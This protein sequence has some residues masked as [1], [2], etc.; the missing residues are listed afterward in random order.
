MKVLAL[1]LLFSTKLYA[2]PANPDW[3]AD[4]G[5]QKCVFDGN[6]KE[7]PVLM[8]ALSETD[9]VLFLPE[10]LAQ[11]VER[12]RKLK[13]EKHPMFEY[14]CRTIAP[15]STRKVAD[16]L[17][18]PKDRTGVAK[19]SSNGAR[20][21]VDCN[22]RHVQIRADL[23]FG[24]QLDAIRNMFSGLLLQAGSKAFELELGSV[25]GK[26][27]YQ[28]CELGKKPTKS[29]TVTWENSDKI[30]FVNWNKLDKIH[31]DYVPRGCIPDSLLTG[32]KSDV[33]KKDYLS[34]LLKYEANE[35]IYN[36]NSCD[37]IMY[38]Q[39][40]DDVSPSYRPQNAEC[41]KV[42]IPEICKTLRLKH[43][44]ENPQNFFTSQEIRD[45][46]IEQATTKPLGSEERLEALINAR[47]AK[48]KETGEDWDDAFV[49]DPKMNELVKEAS[50]KACNK[51]PCE[52]FGEY[53]S[54][55]RQAKQVRNPELANLCI[56]FDINKSCGLEL[57]HHELFCKENFTPYEGPVAPTIDNALKT[58]CSESECQ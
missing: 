13:A 30:Q 14:I 42:K 36:E 19:L 16:I 32:K 38:E 1:A 3:C 18:V 49:E 55:N 37:A 25:T 24:K 48:G 11:Q 12:C 58:S 41:E 51:N 29:F 56:K 5:I 54:L 4:L 28:I 53:G 23:P 31:K 26:S 10:E 8:K 46:Y 21:I 39:C 35:E 57:S 43:L 50:I 34:L 17:F 20:V 45:A 40:Y 47:Y 6:S 52:C 9:P 27:N 15:L 22:G 44:Y 2:Y 33:V 7:L